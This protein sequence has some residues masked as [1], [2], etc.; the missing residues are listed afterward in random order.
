MKFQPA[1]RCKKCGEIL[2]MEDVVKH[3]VTDHDTNW[4][5]SFYDALEEYERSMRIVK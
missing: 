3:L 2:H 4:R 1:Y 5:G